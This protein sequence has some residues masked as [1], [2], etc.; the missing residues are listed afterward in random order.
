MAPSVPWTAVWEVGDERRIRRMLGTEEP[1]IGGFV[2]ATAEAAAASPADVAAVLLP[3]PLDL[4]SLVGAAVGRLV[5]RVRGG[6]SPEAAGSPLASV[7]HRPFAVAIG[8]GDQGSPLQVIVGWKG[9]VRLRRDAT[10]TIASMARPRLLVEMT[11]DGVPVVAG[12]VH[13]DQALA[14]HRRAAR[15]RPES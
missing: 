6:P 3:F 1:L 11:I 9:R 2:A 12:G 4:V 7:K 5:R 15:F 14:L 10:A 13:G 8:P